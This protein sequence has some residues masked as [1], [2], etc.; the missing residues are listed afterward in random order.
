VV[1]GALVLTS[2]VHTSDYPVLLAVL[3]TTSASLII[4]GTC[5]AGV[6]GCGRLK[7]KNET[8][9]APAASIYLCRIQEVTAVNINHE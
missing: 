4:D 1:E 9:L 8:I 7:V 2:L 6:F 3:Y 5:F